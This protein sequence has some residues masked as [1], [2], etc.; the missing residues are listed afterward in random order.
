M[1]KRA[2]KPQKQKAAP[3]GPMFS[4]GAEVLLRYQQKRRVGNILVRVI[5]VRWGLVQRGNGSSGTALEI[6]DYLVR[7]EFGGELTVKAGDLRP[8][9]VLDRIN[10]ALERSEEA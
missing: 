3:E 1:A 8:G 9:T 5:F 2:R 4:E 7:S 6:I 10:L